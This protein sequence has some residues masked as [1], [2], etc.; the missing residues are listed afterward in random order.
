MEFV[1]FGPLSLPTL[2][3]NPQIQEWTPNNHTEVLFSFHY[4]V[5]L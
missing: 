1:L 3:V 2:E 4:C 5:E